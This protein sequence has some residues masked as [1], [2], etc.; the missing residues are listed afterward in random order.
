MWFV[1]QQRSL[2]LTIDIF[3]CVIAVNFFWVITIQP[4]FMTHQI[5]H[6]AGQ[7]PK[8]LLKLTA[9]CCHHG[10]RCARQLKYTKTR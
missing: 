7:E 5:M 1:S 8:F 4:V 9:A 2:P 6:E 10:E 3:H